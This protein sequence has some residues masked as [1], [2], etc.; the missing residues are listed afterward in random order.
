MSFDYFEHD[1]D[2]GVIGRGATLEEAFEGAAGAMFAIM[3]ESAQVPHLVQ[4][5]F[6]FAEDDLELALVTWLNRL[7]SEARQRRLVWGQFKIKHVDG[8]WQGAAWGAP[9]DANMERG[10][11][12]KGATLTM[13]RVEQV[14]GTW[15]ARCVVDV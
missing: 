10:T 9:W 8:Q 12:V 15:E 11:E 2:I 4:V 14:D 13:L 6:S 7:L 3:V 1:A 5:A